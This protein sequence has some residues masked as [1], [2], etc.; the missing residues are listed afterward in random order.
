MHTD[1]H[2]ALYAWADASLTRRHLEPSG[3]WT[4]LEGEASS[5]V[6]FRRR[7]TS[8]G[9]RSSVIAMDAPPDRENNAQF[10]ALAQR[11]RAAGIAVP[12]I[13]DSDLKRGFLLVEDLGDTLIESSYAT[14]DR[15]AVLESALA[16]LVRLQHLPE[17]PS[18]PPYT[19]ERF[20]DELE[21]FRVWLLDGWLELELS[22]TEQS[23]LDDVTAQLIATIEDQPRVCTHRDYHSRNLIWRADRTTGVVDFQDALWGPVS[24]DVA[25]L[26]RDCYVRFDESEIDHWRGRYLELARMA[27]VLDVDPDVFREWLDLTALQRQLK[28]L[29]IFARLQL[30]DGRG[31]HLQDIP[32]VLEHAISIAARYPGLTGFAD[33]LSSR[34]LPRALSR[35]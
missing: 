12:E 11:F 29:G 25:C 30:R 20:T 35:E 31:S 17:D 26:L 1:R 4:P 9:R 15:E 34:V 18:V 24:Y 10:I 27:G 28:A 14:T 2:T 16:T 13:L 7:V 5:R 3:E 19:T 6:F 22:A 23:Q 32:P 33:W 21:L 8:T